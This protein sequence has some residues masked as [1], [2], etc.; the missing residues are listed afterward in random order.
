M[1]I[2]NQPPTGEPYVWL[3]RELLTSDAWRSLGINARR[4]VDFLMIEH[5][6]KGGQ[7]N[8][9]LKAPDRQLREFGIDAR[10]VARTIREAEEVGLVD[11]LR[12]GMRVATLYRLTW[13]EGHDGTPATNRWRTYRSANLTPVPVEKSKNLPD[14][15]KAGLPDKGKADGP[16][17][18]DKGKADA[19]KILPDKGK[20]L[21]REFLPGRQPYIQKEKGAQ[22]HVIGSAAPLVRQPAERIGVVAENGARPWIDAQ[23]NPSVPA[24]CRN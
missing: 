16:N 22:A 10:Y 23:V 19:P 7:H 17:L 11:C 9:K 8:G 13:L 12:G 3:T 2:R 6:N 14:K 5:M 4:F 18:P 21:L 1:K 24:P 15:G 20:V